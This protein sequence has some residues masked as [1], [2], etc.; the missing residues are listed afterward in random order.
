MKRFAEDQGRQAQDCALA[1]DQG[2]HV[3]EGVDG[4]RKWNTTP[5]CFKRTKMWAHLYD[6]DTSRLRATARRLGVRA[7]FVHYEGE[8]NQHVD[9]C[10]APLSRA[11]RESEQEQ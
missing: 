11:I 4:I 6:Q 5:S 1:G 9:L 8:R 7:I 2:L 10:G 3:W